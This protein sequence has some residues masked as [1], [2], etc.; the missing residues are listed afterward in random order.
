MFRRL[1][2]LL[3][4]SVLLYAALP[5]S[6]H[7]ADPPREKGLLI[8][9]LR[10]FLTVDSGKSKQT[11]FSAANLTSNPLNVTF[12]VKQFSVAD[13]SYDYQFSPPVNE[14]V[15]LGI[16]SATLQ[17]NQTMSVPY[18]ITVPAK[19]P[20]G[21]HYYTLFVSA[22]VTSRGVKNTIQA[23]DLL[24]L[25]VN[26]KLITVS[27]LEDSSIHKLNLGHDIPFTIK[28]VNT[29]NVYSFV[30]VSGQLH[31]LFVR[32]PKT[33]VAHILMPGAVRSLSD[34]I[35]APL[36]PGVYRATYGYKTDTDWIIQENSWVVY[37][38]PWFIAL[39]LAAL[40]VAGRFLPHRKKAVSKDSPGAE[41]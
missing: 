35:P 9:P 3:A 10:Q 15:H 36:F 8:S 38:P 29:G 34:A 40:L 23:A 24:Y 22:E 33:S 14:W 7:A 21:G 37:I 2:P 11:N 5:G 18:T 17:P 26:G 32:P 25:T 31:G 16:T 1:A 27:H 41:E 12:S 6:V 4:L 28:P 13:Y 20:P 39:V 19:S 30:Y